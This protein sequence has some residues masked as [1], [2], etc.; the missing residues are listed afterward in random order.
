MGVENNFGFRPVTHEKPKKI[1]HIKEEGGI[2]RRGFLKGMFAVAGAVV[3]GKGVDYFINNFGDEADKEEKEKSEIIEEPTEE[4]KE[5]ETQDSISSQEILNLEKEGPIEF[6]L[7]TVEAIKNNWKDKYR[8]NPKLRESFINAYKEIGCWQPYLEKIFEKKGVPKEFIFLAIPE[9]HWQPNA[10][11]RTGAAGP[12]QFMPKTAKLYDLK[13]SI[14]YD[15]RKDPLDSARACAD[16]LSDLYK[17]TKDWSLAL[18]GYNGGFIWQYLKESKAEKAE[19]SYEGFLKFIENKLNAAKDDIKSLDS[20]TRKVQ[21][22]DT[23]ES[24]AAQSDVSVAELASCNKISNYRNIKAGQILIVPFSKMR[25]QAMFN[26]EVSG[27]SENLNYPAKYYAIMELIEEGLAKEQKDPIHFH[28]KEVEP[29]IPRYNIYTAKYFD[30]NLFRIAKKLKIDPKKLAEANPEA[31]RN[32]KPGLKIKIPN[33]VNQITLA[34]I[35]KETSQPISR[36][37]FLNPAIKKNAPILA[38][39]VRV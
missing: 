11:S 37:E 6:N 14:D 27:F 15:Q 2:T 35:A 19:V 4:Q 29:S 33:K 38:K 16:L 13:V 31:I 34:D 22:G 30:K 8:N 23:L 12:Y 24:I 7:K 39:Q 21:R 3:V 18:S 5:I 26:K 9:S 32:L 10:V 36:L 28:I 25:K 1:K 20:Y 17:A